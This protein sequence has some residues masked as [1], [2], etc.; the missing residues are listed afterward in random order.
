MKRFNIANLTAVAVVMV[1]SG[2]AAGQEPVSLQRLLDRPISVEADNSPIGRIFDKIQAVSGV[3]FIIDHDT[4]DVLPYGDQTRLSVKLKN[5]TL[6]KALTPVLSAQALRWEIAG[7]KVRIIPTEPLYRM[8]RRATYDELQMLGKMH[9]RKIEPAP[10]GG[11]TFAAMKSKLGAEDLEILFHVKADEATKQKA[12]A[13]AARALPGPAAVYF[14]RLCH[15]RGWTWYLQGDQVVILDKVLQYKRQLEK[16][17]TLKYKNAQLVQVLA[18]LAHEARVKLT[19]RPGVLQ[20]LSDEAK[21][22]F[23]LTMSEASIAEALEVISGATGLEF[24]PTANGLLVQASDELKSN[25]RGT[26]GNR[27]RSPFFVKL[28]VPGPDGTQYEVFLHADELPDDVVKAIKAE[29]QKF[30][31]NIRKT[32]TK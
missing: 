2:V 25:S 7:D 28:S 32:K 12:F 15:G 10:E 9:Q 18:D 22:N 30:I 17:I 6:R 29:K 19:M 13:G 27:K 11:D 4:F 23:N 24:K 1:L 26:G 14:D 3:K 20:Y 31:D 21:G 8:C 16:Q 5:V